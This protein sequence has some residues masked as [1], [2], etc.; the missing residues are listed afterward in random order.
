[1]IAIKRVVSSKYCLRGPTI[2]SGLMSF[3]VE[4][5]R[6]LVLGKSNFPG[7]SRKC[8]YKILYEIE[9]S[10]DYNYIEKQNMGM[11]RLFLAHHRQISIHL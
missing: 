2:L 5:H 4:I 10:S 7:P 1:M 6:A 9:F 3:D 11:D 8:A